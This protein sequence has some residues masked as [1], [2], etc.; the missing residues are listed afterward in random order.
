[1]VLS[2][3][4]LLWLRFYRR[5]TMAAL[6]EGLLVP[7]RVSRPVFKVPPTSTPTMYRARESFITN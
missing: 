5:Q 6:I 4:R 3:S 1:M 7:A 2:H